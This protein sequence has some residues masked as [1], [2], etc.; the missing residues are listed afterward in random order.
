[1]G[2]LLPALYCVALGAAVWLLVDP[3]QVLRWDNLVHNLPLTLEAFRQVAAGGLPAWNPWIWSGSPLL[4]DPQAQAFYPLMWVAHALAGA[5]P[6]T[7]MHLLYAVHAVAGAGGAYVLAR[8]LG[9]TTSGALLAATVFAFNPF[10][11]FLATSF[12]N[13]LAVLAWLPWIAFA[14]L[15]A[16]DGDRP[17]RWL[18]LGGLL[19]A[20]AWAAGYPQLWVYSAGA[21]AL[22][23]AGTARRWLR[24]LACGVAVSLLGLALSL[25]QILPFLSLWRGSQRAELQSLEEFLR[26]DVPL[27]S[28]PAIL[29]PGLFGSVQASFPLAENNWPHLG[30]CAMTL[31]AIALLRPR[32]ARVTLLLLG[33][34]ALWL[35]SGRSGGLLPLVYELVPGIGFLRGPYKFFSCTVFA[36]ALL[37]GLGLSDVQRRP[38]RLHAV[39][40]AVAAVLAIVGYLLRPEVLPLLAERAGRFPFLSFVLGTAGTL[41]V[42]VVVLRAAGPTR[43]TG[44][45][46]SGAAIGVVGVLAALLGFAPELGVY[47]QPPIAATGFAA[48]SRALREAR[49]HLVRDGRWYWG[50]GLLAKPLQPDLRRVL[51]ALWQLDMTTGYS[52]FLDVGYARAIGQDAA[53]VPVAT[54]RTF[55]PIDGRNRV[56]DVL[57]AS[58]VLLRGDDPST[59]RLARQRTATGESVYGAAM[60]LADLTLLIRHTALPRVR[61]VRELAH[62]PTRDD[63]IAAVQRGRIDPAAVA[64]VEAPAGQIAAPEGACRIGGTRH[65]SGQVE[66]EVQCAGPGFL[67]FAERHDPGWSAE[68][69]GA[70]APVLRVYGLVLG[71]PV[72]AGEHRIVLR[73]APV[74]FGSGV[75]AS[76]L[77]GVLLIAGAVREGRAARGR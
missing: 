12:A 57:S 33:A 2:H 75:L 67:V 68:V 38:R 19:A 15:R 23:A 22:V 60:P 47:A 34:G 72:P 71:V 70:P 42:A 41:G 56:L 16:A 36:A 61:A 6:A 17:V 54:P 27:A 48:T 32:R 31:A 1:M 49:P 35:A 8:A 43:A 13:E 3:E 50:V 63:A 7:A 5:S 26:S 58:H 37:A 9:A 69:D 25:P 59:A 66:A 55:V 4:A 51:G 46:A 39:L 45:R 40:L 76:A 11:A 29:L 20:L 21:T 24:G 64:L 62:V 74:G 53:T 77:V 30:L 65:G 28:W 14:A 10:T 73:Y 44:A 18:A 52:A